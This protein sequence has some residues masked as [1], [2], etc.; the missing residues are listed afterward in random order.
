M[1]RPHGRGQ[2]RKACDRCARTKRSC[3]KAIPCAA[4]SRVGA[5][6]SYSRLL[7]IPTTEMSTSTPRH[8]P[9]TPEEYGK[10]SRRGSISNE[11]KRDMPES[12]RKVMRVPFLLSY[13]LAQP[14]DPKEFANALET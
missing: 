10:E 11:K 8:Q 6:C 4:C 14:G 7:A 12:I 9:A 2:P 13:T 3:D 5:G 1:T